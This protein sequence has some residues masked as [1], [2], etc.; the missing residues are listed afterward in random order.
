[1]NTDTPMV[2]DKPR[3]PEPLNPIGRCFDSTAHLALFD[4]SLPLEI[5]ICH[6]IGVST[7]PGEEGKTIMHSWIEDAKGFA[8]DT[9]W[10]AKIK[11]KYYKKKLKINYM[12][13]YRFREFVLL[14][15]KEQHPGPWDEK[16]KAV[17]ETMKGEVQNESSTTNDQ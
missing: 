13:R 11:A 16:I 4:K 9:T 17:G 3:I 7:M 15:G 6:G 8:Y 12:V 10:G 14:W 1:M 5:T 2:N